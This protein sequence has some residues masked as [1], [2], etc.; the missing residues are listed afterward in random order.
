[1]LYYR[2]PM[3]YDAFKADMYPSPTEHIVHSGR[4]QTLRAL[5]LGHGQRFLL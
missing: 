3:I 4:A 5:S 2:L 1:M